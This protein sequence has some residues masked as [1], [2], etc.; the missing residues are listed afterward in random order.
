[1]TMVGVSAWLELEAIGQVV[2]RLSNVCT[3][4]GAEKEPASRPLSVTWQTRAP[5]ASLR[6]LAV[7]A[8]VWA[9]SMEVAEP[10]T[11]GPAL[12]ISSERALTSAVCTSSSHG[13]TVSCSDSDSDVEGVGEGFSGPPEVSVLEAVWMAWASA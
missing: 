11:S 3:H 2:P 12:P 4:T 7:R 6:S 5:C 1:M 9:Q 13:S 8:T 10:L